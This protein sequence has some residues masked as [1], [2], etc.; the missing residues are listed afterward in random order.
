MKAA[1]SIGG[2]H[3]TSSPSC[4]WTKTKDLSLA[5]IVRASEVVHFSIVIGFS[6]GWLQTSFSKQDAEIVW[7]KWKSY[8]LLHST[9]S[10]FVFKL[11]FVFH[12]AKYACSLITQNRHVSFYCA[13]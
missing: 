3:V 2:F 4:W 8:V 10:L 7:L 9:M 13:I 12:Y 5:S 6:R 11:T 1:K